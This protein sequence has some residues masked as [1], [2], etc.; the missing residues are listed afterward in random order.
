MIF[1]RSDSVSDTEIMEAPDFGDEKSLTD[2]QVI[3]F[4]DVPEGVRKDR[5]ASQAEKTPAFPAP[6]L[7]M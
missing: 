5:I 2:S 4:K 3:P 1:K 7:T 6:S